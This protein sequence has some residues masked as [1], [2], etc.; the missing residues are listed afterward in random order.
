MQEQ[1]ILEPSTQYHID[2][3]DLDYT[4]LSASEEFGEKLEQ[5]N[6][7]YQVDLVATKGA[8]WQPG[9]YNKLKEW[10]PTVIYPHWK[11]RRG[12]NSIGKLLQ[13]DEW[14][15]NNFKQSLN[16][17]DDMLWHYRK[18]GMELYKDSD[19]D[20]SKNILKEIIGLLSKPLQ[21]ININVGPVPYFGRRL[22]Y[23][24]YNNV[25]GVDNRL[26]PI[27][28]RDMNITG[29]H[30]M[31]TYDTMTRYD[32]QRNRM[33][34]NEKHPGKWYVNILVS[35][36]DVNVSVA[37]VDRTVEYGN[38][39]YGDIIVGLTVDFMTLC[40]NYRRMQDKPGL[41]LIKTDFI[42]NGTTVFPYY[43]A[44]NHP[45]IFRMYDGRPSK[46]YFTSYG[47]GNSCFG[48]L[49]KEVHQSLLSGN[50]K[51]LK[52]YLKIWAS[53]YT[54]G[55][56]SPLNGTQT[57]HFGLPK[58][59]D[60][61]VR[62]HIATDKSI[63]Q[64][65]IDYGFDKEEFKDKF[66]TNCTLTNE[67]NTYTKLAFLNINWF[68]DEPGGWH[69]QYDIVCD[70]F[71]GDLDKQVINE[72]F[73]D[74]YYYTVMSKKPNWR[75]VLKVFLLRDTH[76]YYLAPYATHR[77]EWRDFLTIF[78]AEPITHLKEMFNR[79]ERAWTLE[80]VNY[81]NPDMFTQLMDKT[82]GMSFEDAC[83]TLPTHSIEDNHYSWLYAVGN[84]GERSD[85]TTY[86]NIINSRKDGLR[87]G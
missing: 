28:D 67:C 43:H 66:C 19:I 44:I 8:R 48:D 80:K 5:F 83:K 72:L 76:N 42:G 77:T 24:E 56:T 3:I 65:Q 82:D 78:K 34:N 26:F 23:I 40:T 18:E 51:L 50:L 10:V 75:K 68:D 52:T 63:C 15:Y 53:S 32:E 39:P 29:S 4:K 86:Y 62:T 6:N 25:L 31:E 61:N 11:R 47:N 74:L 64:N 30:N 87:Y 21:G 84:I 45:F 20:E 71:D 9:T 60:A 14:R 13:Q 59:W 81:D 33:I 54:A 36:K 49:G 46:S 2:N 12:A 55:T 70:Y 7:M 27:L 17:L 37:N 35:L 58:E 73:N 79:A 1:L 38:F 85:Y 22:R 57:M 16:T 69:K 41:A